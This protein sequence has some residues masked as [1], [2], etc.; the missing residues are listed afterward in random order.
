MG[1]LR[2]PLLAVAVLGAAA[3]HQSAI[4]DPGARDICA[5]VSNVDLPA[6]DRP[7]PEER[8]ALAGCASVDLYFGFGIP[9]DPVKARK[10]AYV[11]MDQ[12]EKEPVFGGRTILMMVYANGRGAARSFDVALRLACAI[13]GAPQD[14]AGRVHQIARLNAGHWT[15]DNFSICDHS[16]GRSLYEQCAMLQERFDGVTRAKTL[17]AMMEPWST[18]DREAFAALR[19]AADRFFQA[20]AG[21]EVDLTGTTE[22]Q[23]RAFLED[24]LIASLR[25]FERGE[26]PR[27]SGD[28]LSQAEAAMNLAYASTQDGKTERWGTVTSEGIKQT[29][30]LWIAYRDAWVAFAGQK[31]ERVTKVSWKTWLTRQRA[32]MLDRFRSTME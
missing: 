20:H 8:K 19:Q 10:C 18:A 22:V 21:R 14:V 3:L 1:T 2:V 9:A 6:G 26:L 16:S 28:D 4:S 32:G 12:G 25:Q 13:G 11:E 23:E 29:Q 15:G 17:A 31:Y 5:A 27:F 30:R 7:T 24:G